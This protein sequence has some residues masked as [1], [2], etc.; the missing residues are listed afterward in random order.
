MAGKVT[1]IWSKKHVDDVSGQA[2][3]RVIVEA[4]TPIK[5][6]IRWKDALTAAVTIPD[7]EL[8]MPEG[9]IKVNDGLLTE[10]EVSRAARRGVFMAIG[11]EHPSQFTFFQDGSSPSLPVRL[12][13]A[14]D[15]SAIRRIMSDK[16][17]VIDPGHGGMDAGGRGPVNLVEKNVVLDIARYLHRYLK[18]AGA[19]P[20]LTRTHDVGMSLKQRFDLAARFGAEV[21]VSIHTYSSGNAELGGLRTLYNPSQPASEELAVFVHDAVIQRLGLKDRGVARD[22]TRLPGNIGIPVIIVEAVCISNWVEEGLLRSPV[23]KERVAEGIFN[24]IKRFF[25]GRERGKPGAGEQVEGGAGGAQMGRIERIPIRTH[26]ITEKDDIV[27]VVKMY[28]RDIAAPGDVIG[29][30]ESVVAITQG[31]AILPKTVR[32]RRLARFLSKF[33]GKD[34]SLATPPAMQLAINEVGAVRVLLGAAAAALGKM[35]GRKGDFYRVAGRS[36]AFIDDIAGTMP[37]YDEHVVLGP[38]HPE[39]VVA[40]IKRE[41]GVDAF[42]ADVNDKGCVDILAASDGIDQ[43]VLHQLLSDNPFGND[44]QQTPIVVLKPVRRF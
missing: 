36:L 28:T 29:I 33:P 40:R 21:F 34:G 12:V 9:P 22:A 8:N 2:T 3:S 38:A 30:A 31:R 1:N 14:F 15:R 44:D 35:V 23:F 13:I 37:P 17:I 19:T 20:F 24:G 25:A 7:C 10:I 5:C 4:T 11:L 39:E 32:P 42:I 27:E 16:V 18:E 26:I 43:A 41:T 6:D